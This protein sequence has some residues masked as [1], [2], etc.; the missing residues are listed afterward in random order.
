MFTEEDA[1]SKQESPQY[2]DLR[3]EHQHQVAA[4]DNQP[5]K[6]GHHDGY[7]TVNHYT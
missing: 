1:Q 3:M 7:Y 2:K 5:M 4:T 6:Q